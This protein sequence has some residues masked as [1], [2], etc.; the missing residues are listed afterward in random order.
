MAR[1]NRSPEYKARV[2]I[3]NQRPEVAAERKAYLAEYNKRPDVVEK[4]K[5]WGRE[6]RARE[7]KKLGSKVWIWSLHHH[8]KAR[9]AKAGVPFDEVAVRELLENPP[10]HCPV[11]GWKFSPGGGKQTD[12]SPSLDRIKPVRGYVRGNIALISHRANA[13]KRDANAAELRA[14]ADWLETVEQ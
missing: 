7:H 9:A 10:T 13:I 5:C 11:F 4:R 6:R 1:Y 3:R 14:V 12:D 8:A 2:K